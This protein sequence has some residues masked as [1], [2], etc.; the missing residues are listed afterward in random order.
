MADEKPAP[1]PK[2]VTGGSAEELS[3]KLKEKNDNSSNTNHGLRG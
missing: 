3:R 2:P 1:A